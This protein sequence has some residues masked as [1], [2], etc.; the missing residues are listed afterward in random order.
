MEAEINRNKIM[1]NFKS[2]SDDPFNV[3]ILQVWKT[4]DRLWPKVGA[5]KPA[6]KKNHKGRIVSAPTE[7]K[8]LLS[9]EYK[10]RLRTRPVRPDLEHLKIRRKRIFNM[11][12]K[13]AKANHSSFWKMLDLDLKK[14]KCRDHEGLINEIF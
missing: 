6:A 7:L 3:N 2:F 8:K 11:K 10:E 9:K 12:L 4:M 13:L 1:K 14:N 5:T